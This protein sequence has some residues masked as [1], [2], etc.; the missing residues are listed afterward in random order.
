M[1]IK[2]R[3]QPKSVHTM[4]SVYIGRYFF[5]QELILHKTLIF[6]VLIGASFRLK[7]SSSEAVFMKSKMPMFV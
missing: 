2:R 4:D 7:R 1:G 5:T 6:H 3:D